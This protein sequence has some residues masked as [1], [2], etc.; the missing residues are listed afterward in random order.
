MLMQKGRRLDNVIN[1]ILPALKTE[2]GFHMTSVTEEINIKL[3]ESDITQ[4]VRSNQ[5]KKILR[6]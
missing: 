6:R 1:S 2:K 4:I 3:I 5:L